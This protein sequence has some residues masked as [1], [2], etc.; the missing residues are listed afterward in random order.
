MINSLIREIASA[1]ET[2]NEEIMVTRKR[3]EEIATEKQ[4][5]VTELDNKMSQRS[6]YT[7]YPL[8]A[9]VKWRQ[10]LFSPENLPLCPF[11]LAFHNKKNLLI[12]LEGSSTLD[13]FK[14]PDCGFYLEYEA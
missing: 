5:L 3:L 2:L 11:C 1:I 13:K 10:I 14:C 7:K 9:K 8:S 12:C 4:N 6:M